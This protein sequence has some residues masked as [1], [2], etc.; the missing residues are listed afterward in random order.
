MRFLS[1]ATVVVCGDGTSRS[2]SGREFEKRMVRWYGGGAV[3][4]PEESGNAGARDA[5]V[6]ALFGSLKLVQKKE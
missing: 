2:R 4:E 3:D 1:D 6:A 5:M